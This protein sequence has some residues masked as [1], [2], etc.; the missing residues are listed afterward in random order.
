MV[1]AAVS[2]AREPEYSIAKHD[3]VF[4]VDYLESENGLE[5]E[6]SVDATHMGNV[7]RFINHGCLPNAIV[8]ISYR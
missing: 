8:C 7:A 5:A 1:T 3:Y 6:Y 2:N 4:D